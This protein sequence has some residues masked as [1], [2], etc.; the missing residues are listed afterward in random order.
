MS[1]RNIKIDI[2]KIIGL[3]AVIL[4]HTKVPNQY[5]FQL[6]NFDVALLVFVSGYLSYSSFSKTNN[7]F[8]Y[9]WKRIKRLIIPTWIFLIIYFCILLF[10]NHVFGITFPYNLSQIKDSFL[11]LEG[12]GY[13]WVVRVYFLSALIV[14]FLIKINN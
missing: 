1:K 13:I 4:A 7:Y 12:I 14:P 5:I 6:R 10:N 8:E 3:L 9:L 2:I 11:L